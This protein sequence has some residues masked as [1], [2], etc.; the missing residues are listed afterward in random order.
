LGE[1]ANSLLD[2][3]LA[4]SLFFGFL[5]LDGIGTLSVLYS[6][7]KHLTSGAF[8]TISNM[9]IKGADLAAAGRRFPMLPRRDGLRLF[10]HFLSLLATSKSLLL[11]Y[12]S[13][14]F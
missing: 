1:V 6:F 5:D 8:N 7:Y 3:E 13:C 12:P 2:K 9:S 14:H 11:K 10:G 4:E